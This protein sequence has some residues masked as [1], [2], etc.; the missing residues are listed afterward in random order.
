MGRGGGFHKIA[1]GEFSIHNI[2]AM[3]DNMTKN[4][5]FSRM[6]LELLLVF[7]LFSGQVGSVPKKSLSC[8]LVSFFSS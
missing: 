8:S 4:T 5:P 7:V 2:A 3:S 1:V 6:Y